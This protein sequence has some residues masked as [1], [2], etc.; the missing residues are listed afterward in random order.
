MP[1]RLSYLLIS[2][3]ALAASYAA[4]QTQIPVFGQCGGLTYSGS[5]T[6]V[7]GSFCQWE[8]DFFSQCVP[9]TAPPPFG[10]PINFWFPFG[11]SYT[12]TSFNATSVLPNIHNPLG[13]PPFP[14]F[15]GAG[16]ENYVGYDTVTFN[17]SVIF[18]YNYAYGGATINASLVTPF[19]PTVLSLID[20]VN[21]FLTGGVASKPA[22]T[23]WTSA[24]ALFSVWI[25]V[26]DL[27]GSYFQPGDRG[28]FAETLLDGYFAL[29]QKL[30]RHSITHAR[31]SILIPPQ[32]TAGARNFL[33]LN[34]PRVDLTPLIIQEGAAA[35]AQLKA[36]ITD[37]NTRLATR[38][39]SFK[40]S[41]SGVTTWL[42]D[43]NAVFTTILSAPTQFG[44]VDAVSFGN[45]GDFW[46]NNFH[47]SQAAHQIFAKDIS[48]LMAGSLW[49]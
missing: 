45:T 34:V 28:A 23:P 16:G 21:E 41:N 49:F 47:P 6:C 5:T 24:D 9:G 17:K 1:S 35:Q 39:A 38:V 48:T 30:V 32:Y 25:G 11:D 31:S 46:G 20:Q 37:F 43:S 14:G 7:A 29:I 4:A 33:F 8:S 22:T 27:A 3:T 13:N 42:W 10:G 19:E 36:V 40:A 26:N 15:T 12:S 18:T 2:T 44:F